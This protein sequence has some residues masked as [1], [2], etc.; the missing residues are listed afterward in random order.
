MSQR[1]EYW[2]TIIE[3]YKVSGLSQPAFW[4]H[5]TVLTTRGHFNAID[6]SECLFSSLVRRDLV[7]IIVTNATF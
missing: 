4:P 7:F 3:Q 6:S 1:N 2:D 5:L